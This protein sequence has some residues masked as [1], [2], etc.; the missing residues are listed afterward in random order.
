MW[1]HKSGKSVCTS[2][3]MPPKAVASCHPTINPSIGQMDRV[4]V[5]PL[6]PLPSIPILRRG[7]FLITMITAQLL[8]SARQESDT[9]VAHT[10]RQTLICLRTKRKIPFCSPNREHNSGK[11]SWPIKQEGDSLKDVG[12]LFLFINKLFSENIPQIGVNNG[13]INSS[14]GLVDFGGG[15]PILLSLCFVINRLIVIAPS[16][17][18][19]CLS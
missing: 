18:H 8:S 15:V 7:I 10:P 1:R 4:K 3:R 6:T 19:T 17:R 11:I 9:F 12:D 2:E 5:S 14:N 16:P 13:L